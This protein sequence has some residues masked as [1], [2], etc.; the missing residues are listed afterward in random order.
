MRERLGW[1]PGGLIFSESFQTV[2]GGAAA[3]SW[4]CRTPTYPYDHLFFTGQAVAMTSLSEAS[5]NVL[6]T[7]HTH[8]H[9][10]IH[11]DV[12]TSHHH[13]YKLHCEPWLSSTDNKSEEWPLVASVCLTLSLCNPSSPPLLISTPAS[14]HSPRFHCSRLVLLSSLYLISL[15]ALFSLFLLIC[16]FFVPRFFLHLSLPF[17]LSLVFLLQDML[18]SLPILR[19]SWL[20]S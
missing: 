11:T 2:S 12:F 8:T 1:G 16:L 6:I 18:L 14:P 5:P 4:P 15:F 10:H 17:V 9:T 7:P 3:V 13:T 20:V 19:P